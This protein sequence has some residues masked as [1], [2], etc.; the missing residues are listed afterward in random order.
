MQETE[1][2]LKQGAFFGEISFFLECKVS[3]TVTAEDNAQT[4]SLPR[5]KFERVIKEN[6]QYFGT[7]RNQINLYDDARISAHL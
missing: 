6:A 7:I 1:K 2:Q 4:Y 5:R 3:A